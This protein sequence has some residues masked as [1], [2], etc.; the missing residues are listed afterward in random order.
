VPTP[1]TV[2]IAEARGFPDG[3]AAAV[4]GTLT[5]DLGAL[6]AGRS[7]FVQDTTAGIAVYL[8]AALPLALPA[9]T[10]VRLDGILGERYG[11]RTLRVVAATIVDLGPGGLPAAVVSQTGAVGEELEGRRVSVA[12]ITAGT[13]VSYADGLGILVDDG[14]GSIRVIVGLE[15]LAGVSLPSGTTVRVTGPVGQR[16]ST[17]TGT[18]GYRI[19]ATEPGELE[20]VAPPP[21]PTPK[22]TP[23]A[24]PTDT[25]VP[26]ETPTPTETAVPTPTPAP[27]PAPT[28][29]P[30]PS[31]TPALG[32]SITEARWLPVGAV[33][34][35]TGV[36]T[37]EAG[38]IGT[39]PLLA[40]G[41][42]T[43][44][45]FV[46]IPDGTAGPP[47][48]TTLSITGSLAGPYGQLEIR[49]SAQGIS[50]LGPG[51]LPVP[52]TIEATRLGEGTEGRLIS[53]TGTVTAAPTKS[54]SGDIAIS[55]SD[56]SGAPFRVL[57]DG[58]SGVSVGDLRT[59]STYRLVGIVGQRATRKGALDG[60]R[61]WLRDRAD[62]SASP[63]APGASTSSSPSAGASSAPAVTIAAARG[64]DGA[65]AVVEGVVTAGAGLLDADRRQIVIQDP[66]GAIEVYLP[67]DLAAPATG[68][69]LRVAGTVGRAWNAPRLRAAAVTVLASSADLAPRVLAGAPGEATEWQLVRIAGTVSDVTRLGDRWRADVR[70]GSRSVLVMG[71]PGAGIPSTA[72]LDGRAVTIV[73]IVRRPFPSAGDQRWSVVPRGP[74]DVATGP[75]GSSISGAGGVRGASGPRASRGAAQ[76]PGAAAQGGGGGG[77]ISASAAVPPVDLATIGEHIGAV[78]R[79]GG[80]VMTRTSTGFIL[81]D[82]TA[83]GPVELRGEAAAFVELI[84]A[85][86]A[87]GLVGRV[88]VRERDDLVVVAT[89]PAGLVRLGS[90]GETVPIAAA[91]L[92]APTVGSSP[93]SVSSAGVAAPLPGLDG[94]WFGAAG[95][96]LVPA[97]SL[98]VSAVRRRRAHERLAGVI[99]ARVAELGSASGPAGRSRSDSA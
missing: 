10:A 46:R 32:V 41:D 2:T 19:H 44:G 40:I 38:R 13:P 17:G 49:P 15:A 96:V 79:I 14:T 50:T 33:V 27:T 51:S 82:G 68:S 89:D 39:P 37:A 21:T 57:A 62:V 23:T 52:A 90:L 4:M 20:V 69:R 12:G 5:T 30:L 59:G 60:Y 75:A 64:L 35:V 88:E 31:P 66:T 83:I 58:S 61:V 84:E 65:S 43:G 77:S 34:T 29:T 11:A 92:P 99:A 98:L 18:V 81:D 9:G 24:A 76:G 53:I 26:S 1:S 87:L 93:Q 72:L 8:D 6:E 3:T 45:I 74:W 16:D 28:A 85:G 71:L 73:G 36:V 86:D 80:V 94:G 55:L 91:I 67:A 48:G 22:P 63:G 47:R 78:V 97:L 7:G 25:P 56:P 54:T 42:G 95:L 70:V